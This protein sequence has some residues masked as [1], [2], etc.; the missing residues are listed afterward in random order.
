MNTVQKYGVA[1]VMLSAIGIAACDS[2][3]PGPAE[4]TG[5]NLDQAA[6]TAGSAVGDAA[7][8]AGQAISDAAEKTGQALDD[9]AITSKIKA[10]FLSEA[11]LQS[12]QIHVA[13]TSGAVTLT[14]TV[15]SKANSDRAASIAATVDGVKDVENRLMVNPNS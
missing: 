7:E 2:P 10:A 13:T 12:L 5:R 6:R 9:G 11:G 15:D 1:I 3:K 4:T 8:K 14:G